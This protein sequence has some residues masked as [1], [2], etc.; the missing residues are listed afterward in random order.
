[1]TKGRGAMPLHPY[2]LADLQKSRAAVVGR[3]RW[4]LP[5]RGHVFLWFLASCQISYQAAVPCN[6]FDAIDKSDW[7]ALPCPECVRAAP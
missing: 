4:F 1:M 2:L 5:R 6:A 3:R 7:P